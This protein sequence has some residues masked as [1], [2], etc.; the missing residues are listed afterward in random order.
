MLI[1]QFFSQTSSNQ[2]LSCCKFYFLQEFEDKNWGR[3]FDYRKYIFHAKSS[4]FRAGSWVTAPRGDR[5]TATAAKMGA[6][7]RGRAGAWATGQIKVLS[8]SASPFNLEEVVL[9]FLLF[10]ECSLVVSCWP[11]QKQCLLSCQNIR[12]CVYRARAGSAKRQSSGL[13]KALPTVITQPG[14]WL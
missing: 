10:C 9:F 3:T 12:V 5:R 2:N 14:D 13:V 11:A 6:A 4:N 8:C 7:T 1:S